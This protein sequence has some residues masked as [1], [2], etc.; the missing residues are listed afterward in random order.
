LTPAQRPLDAAHLD[1]THRQVLNMQFMQHC[2][3]L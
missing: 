1:M 2:S 3:V